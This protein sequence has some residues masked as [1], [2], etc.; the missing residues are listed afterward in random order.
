MY[1]SDVQKYILKQCFLGCYAL[2]QVMYVLL[3][4]SVYI[5][6]CSFSGQ[7]QLQHKYQRK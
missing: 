4:S 3:P 2:Y 6:N 5:N 7:Q 1:I